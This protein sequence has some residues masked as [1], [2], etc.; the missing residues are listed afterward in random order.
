MF[1]TEAA[2]NA[3]K[4]GDA[5]SKLTIGFKGLIYQM[6]TEFIGPAASVVEW[7]DKIS[8]GALRRFQSKFLM[9]ISETTPLGMIVGPLERLYHALTPFSTIKPPK[10][11]PKLET[12][13]SIA[14][15]R[16]EFAA[17]QRRAFEEMVSKAYEKPKKEPRAAAVAKDLEKA[18][19]ELNRINREMKR[20]EDVRA[21]QTDAAERILGENLESYKDFYDARI[22]IENEY[23]AKAN[24]TFKGNG[25]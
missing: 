14:Q 23:V 25:N 16:E 3:D 6:G 17:E 19:L 8:N 11:T 2:A 5:I 4:L 21:E 13:K 18:A 22:K 15:M 24:P 12:G 9:R 7:L 10:D 20:I 1:D